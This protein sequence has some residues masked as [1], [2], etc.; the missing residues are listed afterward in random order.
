[1]TGARP[2]GDGRL[3]TGLAAGGSVRWAVVSMAGALE[4]ARLRLDLSPLAAVALG[5]ALAAAVLIQRISL[6]VPSRL[7]VEVLGDGALGKIVAEAEAGGGL[8]GLVG[9]PHLPQPAEGGMQI[10]EAIGRGLLRVTREREGRRYS[11]QVELL[12]G[13]LADDVT[14]YLEQSEQIRSAVLLGVLPKPDGIAAAGGLVVE[15]LPGSEETVVGRLESNIWT[16]EG[17]SAVLARSGALA[18]VDEV[19]EGLDPE[20]LDDLPVAYRCR[21]DRDGLRDRLRG[22]DEADLRELLE[23][24]GD[25]EAVCAFCGTTY[26]FIADELLGPG[27]AEAPG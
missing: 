2:P 19:L 4:E 9:S 26:R 5:R 22:L 20:P 15:A 21:C 24:T 8:R 1:M 11:S 16:V 3:V 6:K 14:H 7:V 13:E 27:T 10:A 23:P 12:S 25:C 18:L 17:V